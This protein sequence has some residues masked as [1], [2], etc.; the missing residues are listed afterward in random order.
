MKKI[1]L[2]KFFFFLACLVF[3]FAYGAVVGKYKIF[4]YAIVDHATNIVVLVYNER[5]TLTA[6]RPDHFL[7]PVRYDGDGVTVNQVPDG[8]DELILLSGFFEDSNE[9]RLIRRDGGIVNRWPVK[10]S[11]LFPDTGHL[12]NPPATDWNVDTSGAVALPD[13][14]VVFNFTYGGLARLDRCGKVM[15]TLEQPTHHSVE[16][17]ETGGFWVPSRRHHAENTTSPFPPFLTPFEEDTLI[18]VSDTGEV[19]VEIS[20]PELFR[21]NGLESLLTSSGD[22]FTTDMVW[23]N[24]I[25][26]LNKVAELRSDIADDFPGFKAGDLALSLRNYNMILVVDPDTRKIKWWQIGP[27]LRQHD[28]E[29]KP[30][31]T[32]AIF[33]NN[34]TRTAFG[35]SADIS[36]LDIPRVS[37]VMEVDPASGEHKIIYGGRDDQELLTVIRGQIELT[38]RNGLLITE[39][40]SGRAFETDA[41]GKV[42]WE[43]INRYSP[44]DIAELIEARIYPEAYFNVPSWSCEG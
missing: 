12:V 19:L 28:P 23:D 39:F 8:Q 44:D 2:P 29:F 32:I 41:A 27:W 40:E 42:I 21:E 30:G 6:T 4:P 33:N 3:V 9:L 14:S 43:Y 36:S 25:V 13:G 37:N 11:E 1:D 22:L 26:H 18:K 20:V 35:D 38:P 17:A 15:W 34:I 7:Q 16:R 31:G 5:R 24:E 10:F